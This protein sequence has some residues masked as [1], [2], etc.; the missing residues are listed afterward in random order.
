MPLFCF[1]ESRNIS[2][3]KYIFF[4][5]NPSNLCVWR[6]SPSAQVFILLLT[7]QFSSGT[8]L[9][10]TCYFKLSLWQRPATRG[11]IFISKQVQARTLNKLFMLMLMLV[12]LPAGLQPA[13]NFA[14][15]LLSASILCRFEL[16]QVQSVWG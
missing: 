14:L 3:Q 5:S 15:L 9:M 11:L 6:Q 12:L 13:F 1:N 10:I 2:R 16:P 7:A 4:L 8:F